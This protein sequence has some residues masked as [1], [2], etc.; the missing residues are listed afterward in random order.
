MHLNA[1]IR[2][3]LFLLAALLAAGRAFAQPTGV[4]V[5]NQGNFSDN[6]GSVTYNDL[7]AGAMTTVIERFG[8]IVQ[9]ATL[10]GGVL[11]VMSNTSEAVDYIDPKTGKRFWQLTGVPSP[12]YMTVVAPGKA[13][14]SN[15]YTGTVT[16]V[17]LTTNSVADTRTIRVGRNPEDI[18]VVGGRVYVANS[19]FGADST[20]TVIDAATDAPIATVNL[21]CKGPRHLEVDREKEVWAF[22]NGQTLYDAQWNVVGRVNAAV[23]VVDGQTGAV[24]QRF[25]LPFQ[26]GA[27]SFGQDTYYAPELEQVF[28]VHGKDLLV[29]DTQANAQLPTITLAG[30]EGV[31]GVAYDAAKD[32][33]YA[34]RFTN[35]TTAGFVTV[36][37]RTGAEVG[38]Y[39]AGIAPTQLLL[40]PPA[41]PTAAEAAPELPAQ[42]H[43]EPNYP[44]P[45]NPATTLAFDLPS[46]GAATL[47]IYNALG[48]PV[49]T[50]AGG[51]LPAG[52]H[53]AVWSAEGL[54][55]G[56]YLARLDFGGRSSTRRLMLVK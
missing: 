44:N 38:R 19:G 32:R 8:T 9:S 54:P 14:V 26:A 53:V 49:A 12:R 56:M 52:R 41:S 48:Q 3:T 4:Y 5:V 18:A 20:L 33:I 1:T 30:P 27:A 35:Y 16:A 34:A 2:T 29:F 23:V 51:M 36:H 31:G 24:L 10:H 22:C 21:G 40:D 46:A 55:S 37:T 13:Y 25:T 42:A 6:N 50:L 43:L 39:K 17:N 15:L 45:F 28:Y 11:Y 7:G 47:T